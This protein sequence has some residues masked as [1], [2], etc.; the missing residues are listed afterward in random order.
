[1]P[2]G[3]HTPS[4]TLPLHLILTLYPHPYL[5]PN[6]AP[7]PHSQVVHY[8]P[9]QEY[10]D[11]VDYF[12]SADERVVERMGAALCRKQGPPT[13]GLYSIEQT[14]A[15]PEDARGSHLGADG[16]GY[17]AAWAALVGHVGLAFNIGAAGNRLVSVLVYLSCA[18]EGGETQFTS[19]GLSVTPTPG[20]ALLW[21][22][23]DRKGVLDRR[24]LHCGRPVLAGEKWGMNI[25]FR[26]RPL[27][28]LQAGAE[29]PPWP[30]Q[31]PT[32]TMPSRAAIESA[33]L[34]ERFG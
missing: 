11:H 5:H 26:Q 15:A 21:H 20:T 13:F 25:W 29:R 30:V 28:P 19:L 3:N 9:G 18:C 16:L 8:T 6:P 27:T 23:F 12:S 34:R 2:G 7:T 31:P 17:S 14:S 1:M 4:L 22:N 33:S 10:R 24:T 32:Q